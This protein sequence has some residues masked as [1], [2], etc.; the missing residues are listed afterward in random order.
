M[1]LGQLSLRVSIF[2]PAKLING[3]IY[4]MDTPTAATLMYHPYLSSLCR[5]PTLPPRTEV[6]A[7]KEVESL[8]G[9][10]GWSIFRSR[11]PSTVCSAKG[12]GK[13]VE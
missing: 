10:V 2:F 7:T 12:V 9:A 11:S 4:I 1:R 8:L 6:K 5:L 13:H 3:S